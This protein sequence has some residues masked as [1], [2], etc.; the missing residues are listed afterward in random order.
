[1]RQLPRPPP[2]LRNFLALLTLCPRLNPH[3]NRPLRLR[4][5]L[6]HLWLERRT[7]RRRVHTSLIQLLHLAEFLG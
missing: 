3:L 1:M 2:P 7:W 5:H 4:D 6:L